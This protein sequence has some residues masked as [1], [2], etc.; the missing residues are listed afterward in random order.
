MTPPQPLY[1]PTTEN[2]AYQLRYAW[3]GWPSKQSFAEQPIDLI[4]VTKPDW[5][6]DGMRVLESRWTDEF[7]QILFSCTPDVAP[8]RVAA[9]AKGRLDHAMRD[10]GLSM[11]FSRKVAIRAVG[12]NTRRDV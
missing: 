9:R 6:R 1:R 3:T 2:A 4:E 11:P 8:E 12:D 7:V 10:R 5:E